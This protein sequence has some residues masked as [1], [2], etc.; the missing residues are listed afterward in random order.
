M[1]NNGSICA[2]NHVP[3]R[4]TMGKVWPTVYALMKKDRNKTDRPTIFLYLWFQ[5]K[6]LWIFILRCK[7]ILK[8]LRKVLDV[9]FSL[10][11]HRKMK[12][13][14]R[15]HTYRVPYIVQSF[16]PKVLLSWWIE[17]QHKIYKKHPTKIMPIILGRRSN[18]SA[19]RE[20]ASTRV[21]TH[22]HRQLWFYY[23]DRW[24]R[25]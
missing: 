3:V 24:C 8:Q 16:C 14:E 23:H 15:S 2:G 9:D 12:T 11:W 6:T 5:H 21:H 22:T 1:L 10:Q 18:S 13:P 17:R 19:V 20:L 7:V 25:R 4:G